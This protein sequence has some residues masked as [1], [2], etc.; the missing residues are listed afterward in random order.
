MNAT[1][2]F[3]I[4]ALSLVL[5]AAAAC[6]NVPI[7]AVENHPVPAAA[8]KLSLGEIEQAII[9]AGSARRWRFERVAPGSLRATQQNT[10]DHEAVVDITYSQMAY[11]IRVNSTYRLKQEGDTA[12]PR[13]NFWIRNLEKDIE[14]RLYAAGLARR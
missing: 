2:V 7:H 10:K 9:Q 1:G 3:R 14:D 4:I 8:Q 5:I 12:H 13:L 6:Q 11:S